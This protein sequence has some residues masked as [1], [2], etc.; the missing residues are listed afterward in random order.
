MIG[1]NNDKG[2]SDV[3]TKFT[4]QKLLRLMIAD[5][6]SRLINCKLFIRTHKL[7][8]VLVFILNAGRKG[9]TYFMGEWLII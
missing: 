5:I 4:E 6:L 9:V 7:I 3:I 1:D 8:N 2:S